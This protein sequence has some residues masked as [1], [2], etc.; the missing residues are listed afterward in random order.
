MNDDNS[1]YYVKLPNEWYL[2]SSITNEEL[3]VLYLLYR[4][5][6]QYKSLSLC[7]LEMVSNY[8]YVNTKTNK[9]ILQKIRKAI[10]ALI[11][12]KYII[13]ILD[14][15]YNTIRIDDIT[16]KNQVFYV[17]LI[18]PPDR[19]YFKIL[20]T[21][22]DKIFDYLKKENI[23]KFSFVRYYIA[24]MRVINNENKF[25][26]LTQ[27]KV[28]KIIEHSSTVQRYNK[29]LQDELH[30]IRYNNDYLSKEK[31]YC[32]TFIGDYD[33]EEEFKWLVDQEVKEK[34][35]VYTDKK[36]SNKKRSIQ[37]QKRKVKDD[38]IDKDKKIA[39]LEAE[40]KKY[41]DKSLT[42]E[43]SQPKQ[44][45]KILEYPLSCDEEELDINDLFG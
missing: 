41:E 25:G 34:G 38:D 40:L 35:Y 23:N 39:E 33:A 44:K 19:N 22:I 20:D 24:C 17:K 21:N 45:P 1:N 27:T 26:Y 28:K 11:K 37:Q 10:S 3:T 30:L 29:I 43:K 16:N 9:K 18:D 36:I 2:D 14:L 4:N 5:Y 42:I 32:T 31:K 6:M 12:N 8:L 13:D 15:Q 7:S